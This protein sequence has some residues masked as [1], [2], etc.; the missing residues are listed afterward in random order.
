MILVFGGAYQG[1]TEFVVSSLG[2]SVEDM[3]ACSDK[4]EL[5]FGRPVINRFHEFVYGQVLSGKNPIAFVTSHLDSFRDKVVVIDD[6]CC[7]LVPMGKENREYRE[8]AGKIMQLLSRRA[9]SVYRVF[10]GI[11]ERLK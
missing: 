4:T 8:C 3:F 7:G 10:C 1:K 6:V 11:G 9:D 5:S 2:Y